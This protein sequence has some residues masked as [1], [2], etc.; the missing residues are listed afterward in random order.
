[1]EKWYDKEYTNKIKY[2]NKITNYI[3]IGKKNACSFKY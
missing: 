2:T 3:L 1:M